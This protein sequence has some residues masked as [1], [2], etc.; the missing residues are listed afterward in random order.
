MLGLRAQI[1]MLGLRAQIFMLGL[2]AQIFI[3]PARA[4]HASSIFSFP[5]P[6]PNFSSKLFVT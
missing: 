2:R 6:I 3:W 5:L 1:F 4:K